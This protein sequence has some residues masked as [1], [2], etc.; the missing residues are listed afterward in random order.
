M[1]EFFQMLISNWWGIVV[2]CV[3]SVLIWI[4]LS[5]VL[6]RIFFK[7][8]YDIILSGIALVVL[9][10]IIII[11]AILVRTKLGS[12]MMF[13]QYRPGK[14]KKFF[15]MHKFRTMTS[16][17]DEGGEL[18]PDTQRMTKFGKFIR[19]TSLDELPQL[20][21]IFRGKMSII[22]PRPQVMKNL[23]FLS[24]DEM[25]K[26]HKVRVG[27]T[28]LAQVN[29]R[30]N[31]SWKDRFTYDLYYAGHLSLWLDIKIFFKTISMV[32]F[33]KDITTQGMVS[34]NDYGDELLAAGTI[35]QEEHDEKINEAKNIID[36]VAC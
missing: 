11:M 5:V 30:N 15:V 7:R 32:I 31:L 23:V 27:L 35:T 13:K 17:T 34:G 20:W 16:E 8:F 29:G 12:P 3:L 18:L 14:N 2:I 19:A 4:F 9:S 28:G 22:G 24:D 25:K 1:S 21:D 33:R 10:P 26:R 36:G 6:Y